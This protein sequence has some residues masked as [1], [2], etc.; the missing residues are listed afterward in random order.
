MEPNRKK[1]KFSQQK[2]ESLDENINIKNTN[3][4]EMK[5]K[6]DVLMMENE[7][8]AKQIQKLN[9]TVEIISEKMIQSKKK[10]KVLEKKNKAL[11]KKIKAVEKDLNDVFMADGYKLMRRGYYWTNQEDAS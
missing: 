5:K 11:Q 10:T 7:A 1:R 9:T 3:E 8:K 4:E 2:D 6:I